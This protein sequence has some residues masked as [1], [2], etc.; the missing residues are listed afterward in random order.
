MNS[1]G[2]ILSMNI[3][4]LLNSGVNS[5]FTNKQ[6]ANLVSNLNENAG[7]KENAIISM[8]NAKTSDMINTPNSLKTSGND[9]L[10]NLEIGQKKIDIIEYEPTSTMKTR[11]Q[12]YFKRFGYAI[13]DYRP[14][15]I[16]TRKYYNFVKTSVCNVTGQR[17]PHKYLEEIKEIFNKGV[18]IWHVDNGAEV[19]NYKVKNMEV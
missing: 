18:T 11:L 3:S 5:I 13:N 7:V 16:N 10:F 1:L 15:N 17:V 2:S 6:Y 4:G 14:I 9:T 19:G 12:N 8:A